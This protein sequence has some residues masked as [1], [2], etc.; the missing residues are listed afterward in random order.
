VQ[1]RY[2]D[3][4]VID[5]TGQVVLPGLI[6]A[7]DHGRALGTLPMGVPDAPLEKWL[8]GLFAQRSLDCYLAALYDG[9]LLLSSGV[10]TTMHQH[11]PR[12]WL[13]LEEELV[14]SARGYRDAGIRASISLSLMDRN[15]LSYI[16]NKAFLER[17]PDDLAARIRQ[18]GMDTFPLAW[19]DGIEIGKRLKERWAGETRTWLCWGPVAPQWCSD[20]LLQAVKS[21]AGDM[22]IQIHALET[23]YQQSYGERYYGKTPVAHLAELEFL[24]PNVSCA[25]GVWLTDEDIET[26][27]ATGAMVAHNASSN[28]RLRSGIARVLDL[29][30]AGVTVGIGLDGQALSDDQD[31]LIEIRLAQGLAF[32]PGF[33]GRSLSARQMLEMATENGVQ[34]VG[35]PKRGRLEPG[36][37]ADLIALRLEHIRG[38]YLDS[39]TDLVDAVVG[40][41]QKRD[42]D[43]IVVG[44]EI[45]VQK[46]GHARHQLSEVAARIRESLSAATDESQQEREQMMAA[47]IP[48]LQ[49]VYADW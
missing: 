11:N 24:G 33:E 34:I 17:L 47:I 49:E 44:G 1:A 45:L 5:G 18:T 25:H 16:G 43:T 4:T 38:P 23:R 27:A 2:P 20:E 42:V 14:E 22:P 35:G 13:S 39:R 3:A 36:H 7:H 6:N 46:G 8:P 29:R 31:M 21:A 9:L 48:H 30:E 37:A 26:L 10:T 19:Q 41:A 28:L 40:R 12:N 15:S 32:E